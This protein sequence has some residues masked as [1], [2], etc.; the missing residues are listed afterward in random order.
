MHLHEKNIIRNLVLALHNCI[1]TEET[2][3]N[4]KE[5]HD[6]TVKTIADYCNFCPDHF[7]EAVKTG[8]WT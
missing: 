6:V 7:S 2:K 8:R 1:P 3:R 5:Q 4:I